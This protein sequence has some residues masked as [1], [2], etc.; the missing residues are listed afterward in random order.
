MS[1]GLPG[2]G[3]SQGPGEALGQMASGVAAAAGQ[4]REKAQEY[5]SSMAGRVEDAWESTREGVRRGASAVADRAESFWTGMQD[6]IRRYPVAA[7][8]AAF[9]VGCLTTM[10]L[11]ATVG[12]AADDMTR[13]MSRYSS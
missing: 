1:A 5:A 12:N 9:G 10:C 4:V 2:G 8:A 11:S 7:V 13:R 6:L 3:S